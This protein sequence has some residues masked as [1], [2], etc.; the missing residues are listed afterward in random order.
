MHLKKSWGTIAASL[1][2]VSLLTVAS[3]SFAGAQENTTGNR[4]SSPTKVIAPSGQVTSRAH[5]VVDMSK[6]PK[7]TSSSQTKG[8]ARPKL[9]RRTPQQRAAYEAGVR[10]G[11]IK[12]PSATQIAGAPTNAAQSPSFVGGGVQPLLVKNVDGLNDSQ[13]ACGNCYPPDQAIATDLSYVME[14]VNTSIGIFNANTGALQFGPYSADSFFAPVKIGGDFF[15]DPQM[16]YDVMRDRWVVVFIEYPPDASTSYIDI[17]VSTSTSPTQPAPGAQYN[18]Y[19]FAGDT[20]GGGGHTSFCDYPT[21][22][23]D[24]YGLYV[25]CVMFRD[26][27]AFLGNTTWAFDKTEIYAG[28]GTANGTFYNNAVTI[29]DG[30]S[31]AFRLSP[32]ITEGVQDAE[33]IVATDSTY[34]TSSNVTLCAFTNTL[35]LPSG[36]PTL[37]CGQ[38]NV[39]LAYSD[40]ITARQPGGPNNIDPGDGVKQIYYKAGHLYLSRTTAVAGPSDGIWWAE[41]QPRLST[42]AAHN[43]QQVNGLTVIQDGILSYSGADVYMPTMMG[44]DEDDVLLVYNYSSGTVYPSILF[45]GRKATDANGQFGQVS[46][47]GGVTVVSGTHTNASTRWGDYSA[48]AV[49][50]NSV[51]R[52]GIWCA[53]EYTGSRADP[54]WNTR[55]YRVRLE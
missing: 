50:L 11:S 46:N 21:L 37:S 33:F 20:Q 41:I 17:A 32:V 31:P 19:Q 42:K 52:G 47:G 54:G 18:I 28:S 7:V 35:N 22:G 4:A 2:G 49:P 3:L 48:C 51:T 14:G 13:G 9:D 8:P 43:P 16:N 1:V 25:T 24:Y 23:I 12:V 38:N 10:N 6:L 29:A 27:G 26:D 53:G 30:V 55:L 15:S 39:G 44:T 34:G 36:S 45:N 40:P 5:G